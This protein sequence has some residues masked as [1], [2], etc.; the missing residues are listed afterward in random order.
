MKWILIILIM[1][2]VSCKTKQNVISSSKM[3]DS[4]LYIEK[5][6][7]DTIYIQPSTVTATIPA[8][9]IKDT[10]IIMHS[11]GQATAKLIIK[12][13]NINCEAYC[14][15]LYKIYLNTTKTYHRSSFNEKNKNITEKQHCN[16]WFWFALGA[17]T[18][19]ISTIIIGIIIFKFK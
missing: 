2:T 5:T 18:T 14:D 10:S 9:Q 11:K 15:S 16:R 12:N 3:Q 6:V 1:I 19:F 7:I 13:G 8:S 4:V 17:L